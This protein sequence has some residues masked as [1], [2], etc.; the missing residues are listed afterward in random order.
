[1]SLGHPDL[2]NNNVGQRSHIKFNRWFTM[3]EVPT[4]PAFP[5]T[6]RSSTEAK[7]TMKSRVNKNEK[8][9][10][11]SRSHQVESGEAVGLAT[12]FFEKTGALK[13]GIS[14]YLRGSTHPHPHLWRFIDPYF[15]V[16]WGCT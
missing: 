15:Q 4:F 3:S 8:N 9:A 7:A 12:D 6:D 1:M 10:I 13:V 11:E 16:V 5:D 2:D 14:T